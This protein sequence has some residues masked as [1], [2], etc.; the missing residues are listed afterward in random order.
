MVE[1]ARARMA[2]DAYHD[3]GRASMDG[4]VPLDSACSAS[5]EGAMGVHYINLAR[6]AAHRLDTSVDAARPEFLLYFP[7][8]GRSAGRLAGVEYGVPV[9]VNGV[10]YY[11]SEPPDVGSINPAPTLF[12]HTFDGPMRGHVAAQPWHYDLHV[13]IWSINPAGTFAPWNSAWNCD[14]SYTPPLL[15]RASAGGGIGAPVLS[16]VQLSSEAFT[17]ADRGASLT[18]RL[19]NKRKTGTDVRYRD[20]QAATTTF[21]VLQRRVGHRKGRR[22]LAGRPT[23]RQRR[24]TRLVSLGSFSHADQASNVTVHFTG[25]MRGRKLKPGRYLLA[26]TPR[27]NGKTGRTVQRP[28]RIIR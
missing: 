24:C 5:A 8:A 16:S 10:P 27:A 22:C 11:G 3:Q 1:L 12:G 18:A 15:G 28:F 14:G 23:R 19:R 26:L 25:R 17:A 7:D 6:Y 13:W 2:T 4:F 9:F 21:S 20:S